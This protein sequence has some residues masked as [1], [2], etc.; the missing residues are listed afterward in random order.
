L[1]VDVALINITQK[2]DYKLEA[3]KLVLTTKDVEVPGL[4]PALLEKAKSNPE[5]SKPK[6]IDIK[7]NS[8][9]EVTLSNFPGATG[10]SAVTITL[11]RNK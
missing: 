11:K 1:V 4:S 3:E 2:G 9:D 6:S 5:F 10:A 8:A 7:F